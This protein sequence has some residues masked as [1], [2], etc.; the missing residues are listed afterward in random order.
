M[1]KG[2]GFLIWQIRSLTP[3]EKTIEEMLRIGT[4]WVSIKIRD[5]IFPY[6]LIDQYGNYTG[7]ND[8]LKYVIHEFKSAG[9]EVGGWSFLYTGSSMAEQ[10]RRASQDVSEYG[11]S[12]LLVDAEAINALG[13]L[14]KDPRA[15]TWAKQ[16]MDALSTP[17][18]FDVGLCSYRFPSYHPE[19]PFAAFLKHP[20]NTLNAPQM[21][22][23]MAHNPAY[24]LRKSYLENQ[25]IRT[26]PFV[27]IGAAF[28]EFGWEPTPGEI[29]D[30]ITECGTLDIDGYGFWSLDQAI[31]RPEWLDA[32]AE[33]AGSLPPEEVPAPE[34]GDTV[35]A[36]ILRV[37]SKLGLRCRS[38]IIPSLKYGKT[39]GVAYSSSTVWFN[40]PYDTSVEVLETVVDGKNLWARVGQR[41]FCAIRYDDTIFLA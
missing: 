1:I 40:L 25:S 26:L 12:H 39:P 32:M 8:C 21:Y 31:K 27:P 19:F 20:K 9:I 36:K 7:K 33:A 34:T 37:Q 38:A 16:Y 15:A 2:L 24:Q 10:A 4:K 30:F 35:E 41:Q 28:R 22:W 11:L 29:K 5:G 13:A 6:N 3:L 18:G 14:W 23:M 17:S